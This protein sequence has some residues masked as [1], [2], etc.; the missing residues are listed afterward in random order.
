MIALITAPET[1]RHP[2]ITHR[3]I[4]ELASIETALDSSGVPV[5]AYFKPLGVCS[6]EPTREA[7]ATVLVYCLCC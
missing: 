7:I 4:V 2:P 6:V 1:L 5:P 3:F